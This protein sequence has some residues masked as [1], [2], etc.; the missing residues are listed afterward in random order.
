MVDF[1]AGG[2][3]RFGTD[4]RAQYRSCGSSTRFFFIAAPPLVQVGAAIT[5]SVDMNFLGYRQTKEI[6]PLGKPQGDETGSRLVKPYC[7][8]GM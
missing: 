7:T 1:R 6:V 3:H 2:F 5:S 8:M 4:S